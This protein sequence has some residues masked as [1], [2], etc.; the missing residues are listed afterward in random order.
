VRRGEKEGLEKRGAPSIEGALVHEGCPSFV[1]GHSWSRG[2][3]GLEER[4]IVCEGC[5][6]SKGHKC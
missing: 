3:S 6:K 5:T 4:R 1:R 2:T